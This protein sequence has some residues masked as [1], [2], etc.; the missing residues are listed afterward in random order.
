MAI[1]SPD[2]VW[3]KTVQISFENK[4]NFVQ[5]LFKI[6]EC[7]YSHHLKTGQSSIQMVIFRTQFVSGF[8]MVKSTILLLT[9]RKLD[10]FSDHST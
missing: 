8:Q 9:I 7:R 1:S 3:F 6:C 10:R 4:T 5:R 2:G